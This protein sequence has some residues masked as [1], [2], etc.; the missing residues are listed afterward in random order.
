MNKK[1]LISLLLVICIISSFGIAYG[2]GAAGSSSDPLISKSYI[3]YTYPS[4]VLG[5]PLQ[6][7][8][9]SMTVLEYKLNQA[10]Y[11]STST[12]VPAG[13]SVTINSGGSFT[14]LSGAGTLNRLSGTLID[15]TSGETLATGQKLSAGHR[16][17]AG[18]STS[19]TVSITASS[20]LSSSGSVTALSAGMP[21]TDVKAGD[22]FYDYVL[23]AYTN[24]LIN[25]TT[26][27]TYSPTNELT[28]A[29]AIKLAACIHQLYETGS[30]TLTN[31]NGN[32]YDTYVEYAASKG[33]T[34]KTYPNYNALINREEF[35]NIFYS[36]LPVSE[37]PAINSV[38]D[39]AIPDVKSA[40]NYSARI[41]TF[42]RAGILNGV[43]SSGTFNPNS[44]IM[45]HEISAIV[46]R[47]LQKDLRVSITLG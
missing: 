3:D 19:A 27:T 14:L 30:V 23:Y 32:W 6:M 43:D 22:W 20:K 47:M 41:Y 24:N 28:V 29:S 39:N 34:S 12:T 25:G 42:Y 15:V 13:G 17:V 9:D 11:G 8:K 37:F 38:A 10:L 36:A 1:K 45:R 44:N 18:G 33:I 35:V 26:T 21:F 4:L 7:L 46:A 2:A 5:E 40:S 16:Y 31:G